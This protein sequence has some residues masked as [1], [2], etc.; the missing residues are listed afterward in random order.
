M[1]QN[2]YF[3]NDSC[4]INDHK[5]HSSSSNN[6]DN[7]SVDA[8]QVPDAILLDRSLACRQQTL[9]DQAAGLDPTIL[10]DLLAAPQR[11]ASAS[12]EWKAACDGFCY[13]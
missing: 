9:E 5:N 11:L 2:D 10:A 1:S 6:N 7:L 3:N 13:G 8:D 12:A 4:K